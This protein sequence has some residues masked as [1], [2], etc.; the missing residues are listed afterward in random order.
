MSAKKSGP[1]T[2]YQRHLFYQDTTA[3]LEHE[4]VDVRG[5][6]VAL[7]IVSV[8]EVRVNTSGKIGLTEAPYERIP[9]QIINP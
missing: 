8:P 3:G 6:Q 4:Q 5:H 2:F 9:R 7:V 1:R